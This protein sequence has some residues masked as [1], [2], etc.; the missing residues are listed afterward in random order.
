MQ[1]KTPTKKLP[2]AISAT[3]IALSGAP[4]T[5]A[6]GF[7]LEE[8]VVTARKKEES[9]QDVPV[10][11]S[12]FSADDLQ[13][14]NLTETTELS[15]FT[16][17]VFIE[18]NAAS[19]LSSAKT[20]IR[21]Q[22]QSDTL[23]TL[24]PSV[25]WY[26]DDVYLAR[27][28]G[29]VA[30]MFDLSRV[31]VLKGPQGTLYGRN[32]TGGAIKLI[33]KK[34]ETDTGVNGF[35][36]ATAGNFGT[37]KIG[38]AINLPIIED[39]LAVRLTALSDE[40]KD[41]FGRVTV[42]PTAV[43]PYYPGNDFLNFATETKKAGQKDVEMYR[44]NATYNASDDLTV[45]FFYEQNEFYG[46]ALLLNAYDAP[47]IGYTAPN[48]LL[49]D[50]VVNALQEAWN[51]TQTASLTLEYDIN[52]NLAT[53]L[54]IGW[55]DME[56]SFVS[57]VDGTPVPLN[58]SLQPFVQN[59]EQKSA[60]WQLTGDAM[61]GGLE[62]ITGLFYFEEQGIDFSTTN[63]AAS[64]GS[65]IFAGT[66]NGTIDRNISRS[67]FFSGTLHLTDTVNLTGGLRYT[68]DT[69]PV[70]VNSVIWLDPTGS[71]TACRFTVAEAPNADPS[72]CTW[73]KSDNYEYMSWSVGLDWAVSDDVLVYAKHSSASRAGGQN[74][75]AFGT[76][77]SDLNGNPIEPLDTFQSFEPEQ[78]KDIELGLKGQFFDNS[79][80]VN[81]AYFHMWYSDVQTS[82]LLN[83]PNGLTTFVS[84]TSAAQYDGFEAEVKWVVTDQLMLLATYGKLDWAYDD[85]D[86]Y[87]SGA[88][89]EEYTARINYLL[90][91]DSADIIFD[92]NYSYRGEFLPNSSAGL[93][94]LNVT[95]EA[96]VN[97]VSQIGA[98]I[99]AD[100]TD[101]GINV[102]LWGKN[103]TDEKYTLS[104][105]V[106]STA[107][108]LYAMGVGMPRSYG[109][110]V[111]YNF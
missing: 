89:D 81:A 67:A 58:Y 80:Q 31:E 107:A 10:A 35:V 68:R 62:W 90:P 63:G 47:A 96:K 21:G 22:V 20:T 24:D 43:A 51:E 53:K 23:S 39:V 38:G 101:L 18:Q 57:D 41:G 29:T 32:T 73:R 2:L 65:G 48:D 50:G 104:P 11:V 75:R 40:V 102:A 42:T 25:G 33:T 71:T 86:D 26:V 72:T 64:I 99:T 70:S 88:P 108:S 82:A 8:V 13:A 54:V 66:Y 79:V 100:L 12:S 9:L 83:S 28:P 3:I 34:A 103:L 84:N 87:T 110:D 44:L 105:L 97:D 56:S 95:P 59:A 74:I 1:R 98:R 49:H 15:A 106:L 77:T 19:N 37:Q 4:S 5:F 78:V 6:E 85:I 7:S 76:L 45:L 36:T 14:Y 94:N 27:T 46:N 91:L 93:L 17:S 55:R 60:E 52:D 69:K 111:T 92:L 16:P 30:S 61:D 109:V